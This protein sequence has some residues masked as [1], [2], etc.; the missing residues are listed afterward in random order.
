MFKTRPDRRPTHTHN[1]RL[2]DSS[3]F[4]SSSAT[5][6]P[7]FNKELPS[8]RSTILFGSDLDHLQTKL[9][10]RA[11]PGRLELQEIDSNLPVFCLAYLAL[12]L[13]CISHP[14][15]NSIVHPTYTRNH[16]F[17]TTSP[18]HNNPIF[19][20]SYHGR[21]TAPRGTCHSPQH[22]RHVATPIRLR[23]GACPALLGSWYQQRLQQLCQP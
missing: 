19:S 2:P 12:S 14:I 18:H 21:P 5:Q 8:R 15:Y 6:R 22:V 9:H 10:Q 3:F 20:S 11:D 16:H 4:F 1:I 17:T 7:L 13:S 23:G